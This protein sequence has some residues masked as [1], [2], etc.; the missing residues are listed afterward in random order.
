MKEAII[1]FLVPLCLGGE[2]SGFQIAALRGLT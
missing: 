1:F 2:K